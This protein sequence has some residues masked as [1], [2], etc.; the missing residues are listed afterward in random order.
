VPVDA[1]KAVVEVLCPAGKRTTCIDVARYAV[2]TV[3]T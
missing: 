3:R 1:V 2:F